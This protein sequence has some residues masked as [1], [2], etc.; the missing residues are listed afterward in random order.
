MFKCKKNNSGSTF[1]EVI[2]IVVV[3]IL[4]GLAVW[5]FQKNVFYMYSIM[6][7][8]LGAEKDARKLVK[9]FSSEARTAS[10][11]SDG[12]YPIALANDTNFT[13]FADIDGDSLKEKVHYF[14]DNKSIKKG[15]IKPAGSPLRYLAVNEIVTV[16][17]QNIDNGTTPIF[18]YFDKTYDGTT[19]ALA[20][21]VNVS[22]VR[23]VKI[24]VIIDKSSVRSPAPMRI[25]T[26]V[27]LRNLKDNL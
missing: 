27:S 19:S 25:T 17:A 10:M 26:Q 3:M 2:F 24:T 20:L 11:G 22:S 6:Q 21:P 9:E 7:S 23:L 16:S 14:L 15:V 5:T 4:V 1:I 18:E 12:S 13:F 8:G